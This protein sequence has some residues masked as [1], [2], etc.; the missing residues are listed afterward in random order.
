MSATNQQNLIDNF[1]GFWG[2]GANNIDVYIY[3][4]IYIY[5]KLFVKD[6]ELTKIISTNQNCHA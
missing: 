6:V 3:I 2:E 1:L 4:Y 5:E